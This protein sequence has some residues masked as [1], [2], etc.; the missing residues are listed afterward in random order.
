M[1]LIAH[2]THKSAFV[3]FDR[4]ND[5]VVHS[6]FNLKLIMHNFLS[7]LIIQCHIWV[8]VSQVKEFD[9]W[10]DTVL[11]YQVL[12]VSSDMSRPSKKGYVCIY[13]FMSPTAKCTDPDLMLHTVPAGL[14]L[15]S[16]FE[17][18]EQTT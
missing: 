9:T 5:C 6:T 11:H 1:C 18:V 8:Y 14:D 16:L 10:V 7:R 13:S 12:L 2:H 15:C 4:M 17:S 3:Q